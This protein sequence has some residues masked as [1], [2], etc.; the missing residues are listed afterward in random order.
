MS[1]KQPTSAQMTE[2]IANIVAS[3]PITWLYLNVFP[4]IDRVLLRLT[5][6]RISVTPGQPMGLLTTIG[7]KS[8]QPRNTPLL[9]TADGNTIILI[10]SNGGQ[11][12]HPAWYYNLRA[13]P[14]VRF[15]HKGVERAYIVREV[16]GDERAEL[17]RKAA[18]LYPGYNVY[19][20]R[21]KGRE[22]PVLLL[23]PKAS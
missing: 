18:K 7:A 17:W 5:Q 22:I 14:E 16:T 10:A 2:R 1:T 11:P 9:Y 3:P 20:R 13:N 15:L 19:Q 6:G 4:Y 21:A 12:R 8:G 23:T